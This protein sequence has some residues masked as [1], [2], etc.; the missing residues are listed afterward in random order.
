[1]PASFSKAIRIPARLRNQ[2]L[3]AWQTSVRLSAV[4]QRCHI[5]VL[6]D[7]HG[8]KVV[9]FLWQKNCGAKT[10]YELDL[11]ARRA[12][13]QNG[14]ASCNCHRFERA[15]QSCIPL[16]RFTATENKRVRRT[17]KDPTRFAI[18]EAI[19]HFSLNELPITR[20]LANIARSIG[21]RTLSDLHGRNSCQLLKYKNCGLGVISEIQ[22]LIDRAVNGEF[23]VG[24][25]EQAT[26][27]AEL[28]SLLEQAL[29]KLPLRDRKFVLARIGARSG[30]GC[31]SSADLLCQTYAEIGQRY[32]LTRARI[33]K[34]FANSM[35][36][37]R[38][39]WGPR[40]PRLLEL[41]KWHCVSMIGPLTPP[42]LAKWVDSSAHSRPRSKT[43]GC[44]A[45]LRLSM[46]AHVRL[47]AALDKDIPCWLEKNHRLESIDCSVNDFDLALAQTVREAESHQCC[48]SLDAP[49]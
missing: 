33:H 14:K 47:I 31:S 5:H 46:E 39:M 32:G 45:R 37:L 30:K 21:A 6:G 3:D 43:C 44:F 38:K 10:L 27:A 35:D 15:D 26:A 29:M 40:I 49:T 1:M 12:E 22:Q 20:R 23:D 18:P 17:Q 42:L 11:L 19:G 7:L 24:R 8:R 34:A 13:L 41:V 9:D 2:K 25:I 36:D 16:H 28:L 48:R 4:L